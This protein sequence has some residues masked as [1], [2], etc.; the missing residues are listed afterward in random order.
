MARSIGRL[1]ALAV[2]KRQERG[3]HADG[4][5]L[6]LYVSP[7]GTKS[8]VFMWARRGKRREMGL[9]PYPAVSLKTARD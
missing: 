7:S 6:C 4:G 8:W 9:G 2:E 5:G 1:T 3:R